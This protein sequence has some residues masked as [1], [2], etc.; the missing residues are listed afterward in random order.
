MKEEKNGKTVKSNF[1]KFT[2][3]KVLFALIALTIL[4]V[5]IY[6]FTRPENSNTS[7][8]GNKIPPTN[9]IT[10]LCPPMVCLAG[11]IAKNDSSG[12]SD[13]VNPYIT[14]TSARFKAVEKILS[15]QPGLKMFY[16]YTDNINPVYYNEPVVFELKNSTLEF[17]DTQ[18]E[19]IYEIL[20]EAL[21]DNLKNRLFLESSG[22]YLVARIND[23]DINTSINFQRID[24]PL[25]GTKVASFPGRIFE[26]G[27]CPTIEES[28]NNSLFKNCYFDNDN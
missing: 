2:V 26:G 14:D 21:D 4:V 24:T 1:T 3:L 7:S 13:P 19:V 6:R 12:F 28:L 5:I 10:L 23:E 15:V 17:T 27:K 9:N 20:L 25:D 8:G 16:A 11:N 18:R 22:K